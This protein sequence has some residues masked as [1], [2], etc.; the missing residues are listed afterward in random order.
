MVVRQLISLP[1]QL[2]LIERLQHHIYLSSSLVFVSGEQ[3]S[4]KSTLLE[5]LSNKLPGD[6]QEA[7]IQLNDQLSDSQ[8]R[9]QIITQLYDE[10]LFNAQDSLFSSVS[11]LQ[12]KQHSDAPRL[13]IFDNAH[14]LSAGLL[15]ELAE[16]ITQKE[17][18]GENEINV[19]L[20]ADEEHSQQMLT[21]A[22][23]SPANCLEFKLEALNREEADS[24]LNHIFSQAGYHHQVQHQ[25][26]L[27]KQ[28]AVCA[29]IPQKIIALAEQIIAGELTNREPSWLKT[30]LPAVAL[31]FFLL[32][33]AGGLASY[34]YP[35][36][37]KPVEPSV[38]IEE[39]PDNRIDTAQP[40][41]NEVIPEKVKPVMVEEL[42]GSWKKEIVAEIE[43]NSLKV[44]VSDA[45]VK[46]VVI[47]EQN[48]L[49]LA[50]SEQ[51]DAVNIEQDIEESAKEKS[52]ETDEQQ[53]LQVATVPQ[54][55]QIQEVLQVSVQQEA[56]EV[57]EAEQALAVANVQAEQE[58][59]AIQEAQQTPQ[60]QEVAEVQETEQAQV[61]AKVQAGQ[62]EQ[63]LQEVLEVQA[64]QL[65]DNIEDIDNLSE[66]EEIESQVVA[67]P[68]KNENPPLEKEEDLI[69][70]AESELLSVS[71]SHYTLQLS[72]MAAEKS[73][74]QFI[75]QYGLP[76][77]DLHIYQT[78]RSNK[79][80]YVVI[81]GEYDSWQSAKKASQALPGPLANLD[82]WIKK[83]QLVHQD[84]QLNNE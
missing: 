54:E 42:A 38:E 72:A 65:V 16:L 32:I 71:P 66:T 7:F 55:P 24:L 20:L 69:F 52:I 2:Q 17:H 6:V 31:M 74:Q 53:E 62:E 1:S 27:S 80:W 34:L 75:F 57:Q 40:V 33:V 49:A 46:H 83:Y 4:G 37:I 14:Y 5:Q 29:G 82:S 50:P 44:G 60:Q 26:A 43:E 23:Q 36:F 63:E 3:G 13:I 84:L 76:K 79:P 56:S 77:G 47:S 48:I 11:L 70:T 68:I 9:Q 51:T 39:V 22:K 41:S 64:L 35:I 19:L 10:P 73:L 30:R 21:S 28:L 25:D 81:F 45:G 8:I 59:L 12:E 78:I 18:L 67:L 58:A 15:V 61:V